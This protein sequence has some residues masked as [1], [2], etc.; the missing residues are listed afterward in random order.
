MDDKFDISTPRR[1]WSS[2]GLPVVG[3]D[4]PAYW[5][6]FDMTITLGLTKKQVASLIELA[7]LQRAG[8]RHGGERRRH[9]PVYRAQEVQEA[10]KALRQAHLVAFE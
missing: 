6:T 7:G 9:V 3:Y 10:Y 4:D 1:G 8:K 2:Q 5:S